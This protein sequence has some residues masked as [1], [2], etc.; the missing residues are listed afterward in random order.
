MLLLVTSGLIYGRS[1]LS[2][3]C[4]GDLSSVL[5]TGFVLSINSI[6]CA[7][8]VLVVV[9][10]G[11]PVHIMN[12]MFIRK[13]QLN[14]ICVLFS[15]LL[16]RDSDLGD[17]RFE[18][19]QGPCLLQSQSGSVFELFLPNHTLA[20]RTQHD[21]VCGM[22]LIVTPFLVSNTISKYHIICF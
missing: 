5:T 22:S 7:C 1:S 18:R 20:F 21:T 4:G 6:N 8:S 13:Q 3:S 9:P 16:S 19:Q 12:H 14:A 15:S 2:L 11:L 17:R 10:T